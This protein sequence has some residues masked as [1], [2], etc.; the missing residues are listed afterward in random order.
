VLTFYMCVSMWLLFYC[1]RLLF[2]LSTSASAFI[3]AVDCDYLPSI[4]SI[5]LTWLVHSMYAVVSLHGFFQLFPIQL[6]AHYLLVHDDIL[7][8]AFVDYLYCC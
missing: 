7:S 4:T 1:C 2:D 8:I 3:I 6:L 5:S